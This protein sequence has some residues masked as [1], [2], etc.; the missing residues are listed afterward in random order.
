VYGLN[1]I[2]TGEPG[3]GKSTLIRRL[4]ER[5]PVAPVGFIT[6]KEPAGSDGNESVY[7]CSINGPW[8]GSMKNRVGLCTPGTAVGFPE[9]FESEGVALLTGLPPSS[10]VV[11]DE[12]G[13][14]E[15]DA[16]LF[17]GKVLEILDGDYLVIAAVK[18]KNT[19]FL[20][21]VCSH[22]KSRVYRIS[23]GNR[24]TLADEI[25]MDQAIRH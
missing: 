9:V 25:L 20:A 18:L 24:E 6:K 10:L 17:C 7:I 22:E 4:L 23:Q 8:T 14:M 15:N 12:L 19:P 11:M 5:L 16:R 3:S 2:I 21:K 13:F 1:I